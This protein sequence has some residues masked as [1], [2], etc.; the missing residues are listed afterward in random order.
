MWARSASPPG[1]SN[2]AVSSDPY[3]ASTTCQPAP[4]KNSISF[5]IFWSGIDAVEA[6]AVGV[7]DE[8]HVAE[9]L[10]RRVGDR[11]PHVAL[12]ELGVT[13]EG[14]E[15]GRRAVRRAKWASR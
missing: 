13:G 5:L 7:D 10:Q 6:L 4:S 15:A 14:D 8:H 1:R 9:P 2:A 3:L 12:V 11:L